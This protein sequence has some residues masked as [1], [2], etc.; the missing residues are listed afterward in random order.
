MFI[1]QLKPGGPAVKWISKEIRPIRVHVINFEVH[2]D[3]EILPVLNIKL[4][5]PFSTSVLYFLF[6]C[7]IVNSTVHLYVSVILVNIIMP[8]KWAGTFGVN[9]TILYLF[10]L[11]LNLNPFNELDLHL[12]WRTGIYKNIMAKSY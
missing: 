9:F 10:C 1:N 8:P 3:S 11:F 5:Y 7:N 2:A 6:T 12:I 4:K